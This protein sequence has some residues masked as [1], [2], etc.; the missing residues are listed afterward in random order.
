MTLLR[1]HSVLFLVA[2]LLLGIAIVAGCGGDANTTATTAA[3]GTDTTAGQTEATQAAAPGDGKVYELKLAHIWG[4]PH[5]I[6]TQVVQPWA[7]KI[8]EATDGKVK[9]TSYP[10]QTLLKGP[11]IYEGV[12]NGVADIGISVYAYNAGRFPV[13]EAFLLPGVSWASAKA[14]GAALQEGLEK[15]QPA[16]IEDTH[17]LMNFATGPG[18]M[19]MKK[20]VRSLADLSGLEIG[21]TAG[22][23]GDGLKLLG[24]TPVVMPMPETY[25]AQSRGVIQ[26]TVGPYE[27]MKGFK[28]GDVTDS[29]TK[30]PFLYVNFFFLN[31]N[32]QKWDELPAEYQQIITETSQQHYEEVVLGLFDELNKEG[33]AEY[34]AAKDIEIIE[35]S[36]EEQE[37]WKAK[38]Q[39]IWDD[40]KKQLDSKGLNG[41]EIIATVQELADKYNQQYPEEQ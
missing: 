31:V 36:A 33:L 4:A 11:E 24:A 14:S 6:E 34:T 28:L 21:A 41:E 29:I 15:L 39:P 22:P 27:A 16:E 38:L 37:A 10:G 1:K 25:E 9:I 12:V 13:V 2:S 7:Q 18:H 40:Y 26:G 35:L 32:K 17:V 30:T 8:S 5:A 20:P 3:G 19:L 23:R